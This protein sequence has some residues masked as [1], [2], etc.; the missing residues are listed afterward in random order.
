[1]EV[2]DVPWSVEGNRWEYTPE[3]FLIIL[4]YKYCIAALLVFL[5]QDFCEGNHAFDLKQNALHL[6]DAN[7]CVPWNQTHNLMST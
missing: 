7:M 3:T 6:A 1:M 4:T 2:V 5:Y